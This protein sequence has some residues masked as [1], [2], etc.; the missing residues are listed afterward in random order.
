MVKRAIRS[1]SSKIGR[2]TWVKGSKLEFYES[3]RDE[4]LRNA[5]AGK[6]ASGRFY[7]KMA[8]LTLLRWGWDLPAEDDGPVLC[9]P[10]DEYAMQWSMVDDPSTDNW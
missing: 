3:R 6:V 10:T 1:S 4:Y 2:T 9:E 8:R 7:A 5:A